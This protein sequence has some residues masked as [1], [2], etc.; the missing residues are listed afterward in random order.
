MLNLNRQAAELLTSL[1]LT[2]VKIEIVSHAGHL[3]EEPGALERVAE[4]AAEWFRTY[5]GAGVERWTGPDGGHWKPPEP[6]RR[7]PPIA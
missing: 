2:D 6:R 5:L 7:P 1:P 3:F 4:L